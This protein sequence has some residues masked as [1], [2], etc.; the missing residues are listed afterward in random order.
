[1]ASGPF[2]KRALELHRKLLIERRSFL[3]HNTPSCA[4]CVVDMRL[5]EA[6][7]PPMWDCP[8]CHV[9]SLYEPAAEKHK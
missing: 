5:I 1:M 3:I 8:Q 7:T 4:I 2:A 6:T 9:V